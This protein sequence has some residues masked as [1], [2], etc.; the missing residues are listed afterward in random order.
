VVPEDLVFQTSGLPAGD[1]RTEGAARHLCPYRRHDIVRVD[2]ETFYVLEDNTPH[3]LRRLL[4]AGEPGDHAAAV[5]RSCSPATVVAPVEN[6]PDELLATLTSVA[7]ST[8]SAD[9]TVVLMTPGVYN[10][11]YYEHSFLADKLGVELVEGR[12]LFIKDDLVFMRT[13]QGP[14]R[15]DVIYRRTDDDFLDPPLLRSRFRPGVPGLSRP[16]RPATSRWPMRSGPELPTT[17]RS[18]ATCRRS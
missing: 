1:E 2:A 16:T 15:V 11:A 14:K 18:T 7:P 12:D 5:P 3:A 6:Y 17:R 13:T 9:P 10:S 4:Y 8:S